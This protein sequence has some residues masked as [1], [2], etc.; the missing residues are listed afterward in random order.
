LFAASNRSPYDLAGE[1]ERERESEQRGGGAAALD[2]LQSAQSWNFVG[3]ANT[4]ASH[5]GVHANSPCRFKAALL[6]ADKGT[7]VIAQLS[8]TSPAIKAG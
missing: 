2:I 1:R 3:D 4:A 6:S 7:S 5:S 8:P